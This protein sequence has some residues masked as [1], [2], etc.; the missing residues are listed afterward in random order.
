NTPLKKNP[1][2]KGSGDN[3]ADK[4]FG[5]SNNFKKQVCSNGLAGSGASMGTAGVVNPAPS[6]KGLCDPEGVAAD[7]AGNLYIADS[8]NG[9]VLFYDSPLVKVPGLQGSGETIADLEVGQTSFAHNMNNFGGARALS[10]PASVVT[11]S[12]GHLYVSDGVNNRVLGWKK[13]AELAS[14][15]PADIEIGQLS[16]YGYACTATRSGL[17][18]SHNCQSLGSCSSA[19][20]GGLAVDRSGNLYVA[21]TYNN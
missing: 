4:V 18:L 3:V 8:G 14:G 2:V 21:D 20:A 15:A 12:A 16:F 13:A 17:C 6:T 9:R 11:D 10:M 19:G 1:R 5:Q 7:L